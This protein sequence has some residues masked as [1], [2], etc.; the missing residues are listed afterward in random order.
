M[1]VTITW[2]IVMGTENPIT[3]T[4]MIPA[5]VMEIEIE[6]EITAILEILEILATMIAAAIVEIMIRVE[7]GITVALLPV[8]VTIAA[9]LMTGILIVDV[10]MT[11]DV[12]TMTDESLFLLVFDQDLALDQGLDHL[13][14]DVTTLE[15]AVPL[16]SI[17]AVLPLLL[18]A[19][20]MNTTEIAIGHLLVIHMHLPIATDRFI[21]IETLLG[22]TETTD[23]DLV[24]PQAHRGENAMFVI[25]IARGPA[26]V[27]IDLVIGVRY[28]DV[29]RYWYL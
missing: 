29:T 24:L 6:I 20:M 10:I 18:A 3:A 22:N 16:R 13:A 9:D 17:L 12:R 15:S 26:Q 4:H 1:T 19:M 8:Y 23:T 25:M 14:V 5:V 7:T 27:M 2:T 11:M 21:E 28:F